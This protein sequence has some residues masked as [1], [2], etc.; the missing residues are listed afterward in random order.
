MSGADLLFS[1]TKVITHKLLFLAYMFTS[2]CLNESTLYSFMKRTCLKCPKRR[3]LYLTFGHLKRNASG[4]MLPLLPSSS[5][6]KDIWSHLL[7]HTQLSYS[8]WSQVSSFHLPSSF[9][10]Y[11]R[12]LPLPS[13]LPTHSNQPPTE[14]LSSARQ[15]FFTISTFPPFPFRNTFAC[16]ISPQR[17]L[18][19]LSS[20]ILLQPL[21]IPTEV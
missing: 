6:R 12:F 18:A 20:T 15:E 13:F 17:S 11:S 10:Y 5:L 14:I 19:H 3:M 16:L 1:K 9:Y 4:W 7:P 21:L 8:P 2:N